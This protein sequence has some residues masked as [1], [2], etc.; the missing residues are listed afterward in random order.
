MTDP[1]S[2]LGSEHEEDE[3]RPRRRAL[4]VLPLRDVVLFPHMVLPLG[5]V[6]ER[7]VRALHEAKQTGEPVLAVAQTSSRDDDPLP[8]D[9]YDTGTIARP[10]QM[11][12]LPDGTLRVVLEGTHRAR[13]RRFVQRE[14]FYRATVTPVES[15]EP[16]GLEMRAMMRSI[17]SQF[18]EAANLSRS[19]PPEAV[20]M[21]L[22]IEEPGRLAD[23]VATY[24][25]LS[26]EDKQALLEM[27]DVRARL[28]L[29]D[30]MLA[31]ELDIL[32]LERDIHARV[33]NEIEDDQ[34]EHYLREQLRAIQDELGEAS[35]FASEI[36]DYRAR[37]RAAGMSD[38]AVE[39]ALHELGRLEQMP[40]ASPEFSVLRTYL[41]WLL[42]LP[43]STSTSDE[44]DINRAEGVLNRDHYGL[45]KVKERVLEF[46][47]VRQLTH[48][49]RGPI[50]CFMGP[51]GVGKTSIGRSIA[52]SM[53]REFIRISLGGVHDEAEI[54]GHRRTYVAALPGRI[55]QALRNAKSNNPVFMID[56][57]D[58]VGADFRG[59]PTSALLEV[60]DPEQNDSFRDHYLEVPFDL[61]RIMFIATGNM[62]EPVP[63]A[64]RDRME[65]IEFPGYTE[66]E[67]LQIARRF[68][69]PKQR[70]ANGVTG[71][72]VRF[73]AAGLRHMIVHYTYEAGV[74]NLERQIGAVCRK[75]ARRVAGGEEPGLSVG[76]EVVRDLLGPEPHHHD[77]RRDDDRTGVATGLTYTPEGG[78]I[79]HI[80]V[81]IVPGKGNLLLTGH[82]GEVMKESAQAALG[83]ARLLG[84]ELDLA[85]DYFEKRDVHVHV[86]AGAIPKE[87]P[88]AGIAICTALMS[89]LRGVPVRGDVALTGEVTL[90]G[91]A[92]P[93][94]GVREKVLAAHRAGITKVVLPREN[95]RD[96]QDPDEIPAQV[97]KEV[98]FV[99]VGSMEEVLGVALAGG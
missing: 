73:T 57:I 51:P 38:E 68:L 33:H 47:A 87:G 55:I 58:K 84:P 20:V 25:N 88:S 93:V 70:E 98:E 16:G 29:L 9:L 46:L 43:W 65:V 64:L 83:Y 63:P 96:L 14:P 92:L 23:T 30:R 95:E 49:A 81:S 90:H 97:R 74:R 86:P 44:L 50:L 77:R 69:V 71:K 91:R 2:S 78:D 13:V 34:R 75:V 42:D 40:A 59:D 36:E 1:E 11:L 66:D 72:H 8:R 28:G 32:R 26:V 89:A 52:R 94:G 5:I 35:D 82:L 76:V 53:G 21:A 18:E 48:H 79:I 56:E 99:F 24:V 80:E 15:D 85:G 61:S 7:S 67:K 3:G 31:T 62:L 60:L 54:R 41:D 19:I 17:A 12:E 22:N 39:K 27:L 37:V 45:K 4:P 6:R 10:V